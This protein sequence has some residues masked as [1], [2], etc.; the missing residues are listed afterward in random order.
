M[1][2]FRSTLQF[3]ST[4]VGHSH[5]NT[6][7]KND[8]CGFKVWKC[9]KP[10]VTIF[11]TKWWSLSNSYCSSCG[12]QQDT[13][14]CLFTEEKV[15][16]TKIRTWKPEK[17]DFDR[18]FGGCLKTEMFREMKSFHPDWSSSSRFPLSFGEFGKIFW[19]RVGDNFSIFPT[20]SFFSNVFFFAFFCGMRGE[21]NTKLVWKRTIRNADL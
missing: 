13:F 3:H 12:W 16:W 8:V 2:H 15:P 14:S 18:S 6:L 17:V 10:A 11:H 20:Q 9:E 21:K 1:Y 19:Y 4:V 5:K 7:N